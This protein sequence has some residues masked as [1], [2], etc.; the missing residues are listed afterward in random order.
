VFKDETSWEITVLAVF[1]T[2]GIVDVWTSAAND[3]VPGV[4]VTEIRGSGVG[5]GVVAAELTDVAKAE[6]TVL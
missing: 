5:V 2:L 1:T 4:A 3:V 6:A